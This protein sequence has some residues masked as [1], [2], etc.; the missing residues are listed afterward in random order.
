MQKNLQAKILLSLLAAGS[1]GILGF[2]NYALAD[3]I[4][5]NDTNGVLDITEGTYTSVTGWNTVSESEEGYVEISGANVTIGG[6]TEITDTLSGGNAIEADVTKVHDNIININGNAMVERAYGGDGRKSFADSYNNI[7]TVTDNAK[8][9]ELGGGTSQKTLI[10]ALIQMF[11]ITKY[12]LTDMQQLI[13]LAAAAVKMLTFM[14]TKLL[15][16]AMQPLR[17][18]VIIHSTR[19]V[20]ASLAAAA[21][22]KN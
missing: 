14:I 22:E 3:E 13:M 5:G 17:A 9:N 20:A 1:I 19:I 11:I 8:T 6:T 18:L 21:M 4:T 10:R 16:A 12:I 15:S 2:T 7:L